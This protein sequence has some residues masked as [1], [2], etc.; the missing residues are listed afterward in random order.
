MT[1]WALGD[2]PPMQAWGMGGRQVCVEPK[3]G[4][5]FD[6]Q[7]IVYEYANGVR[8]FGYCRDIPGCY[9]DN[10][11][12][13]FGTKGRAFMPS[14]PQIEGEKPWRYQTG[15]KPSMY[16][17]EHKELFDGHPCRQADQQRRLHVR[18]H[19]ARNPRPDGRYTGSKSLGSRP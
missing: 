18:G 12:V 6:H 19:H 3:Y 17:V 15:P 10:S 11:N 4:D 2:V 7:A 9:G 5:V 13:I 16:D 8:V 1:S 14:S